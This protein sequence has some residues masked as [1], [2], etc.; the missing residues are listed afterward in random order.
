[1][2]PMLQFLS[3]KKTYLTAVTIGVL[4][5]GSWQGW[6]QIPEQ[7]YALLFAACLAFLRAGVGKGPGDPPAAPAA[8]PAAAA[9]KG[10]PISKLP[11]ML[12]FCSIALMLC[13]TG[14][15]STPQKIA[16]QSAGTA[17]VSVD[18]AMNLW[19]AY[20][21]ANHPPVNQELA[22]K[23]AY[24]KYQAA[25]ALACDL[26]AVYA[27]TAVTNSPAVTNPPSM[28]SS[29]ALL[30]FQQAIANANAELLDLENL[31]TQLGVKLK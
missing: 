8:D 13:F 20:V 28:Q 31:L 3:G 27:A 4:L 5:F 6:W 26:G 19:G 23:T 1:M 14:C 11:L 24:E 2:N 7:I 21:A 29:Q 10:I 22:V 17:V 9:D 30:A 25:M 12:A 18:V 15:K 16:Y